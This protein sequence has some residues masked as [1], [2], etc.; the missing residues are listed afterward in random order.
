M[1]NFFFRYQHLP[2]E[3]DNHIYLRIRFPFFEQQNNLNYKTIT[4][5]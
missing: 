1:T 2:D 4:K 3:I 5:D